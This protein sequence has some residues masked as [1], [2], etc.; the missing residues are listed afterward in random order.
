[1][2]L[3]RAVLTVT[4]T[5]IFTSAA[6]A[7]IDTVRMVDFAF[8]PAAITI[9]PG[10]TIV[11]KS[12]QQCCLLHTST[13]S[14]GPMT[15]NAV[16]PLNTT[17][18]VAFN[19]QGTFNYVCSNHVDIGMTGSVTVLSKVPSLGWLGLALLLS[20]LAAA[21]FWILESRRKTA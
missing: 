13:R 10:D 16:V 9:A 17:F 2:R 18:K 8:V 21:A 5:F 11:W 12:T 7:K 20:S 19:Q 6:W 15:W 1:M 3:A 14:T 4:A